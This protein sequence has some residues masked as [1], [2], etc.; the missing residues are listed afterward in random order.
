MEEGKKAGQHGVTP[1]KSSLA[2]LEDAIA[3][4]ESRTWQTLQEE[5]E[6]AVAFEEDAARLTAEEGALLKSYMRRDVGDLVSFMKDTGKGLREWLRFDLDVLEDGLKRSLL[7]IADHTLTD[8]QQLEHQLR[9]EEG[10]YVAGEVALPGML[11]C[12]QCGKMVC[13]VDVA[14]VQAC[15]RCDCAF[16]RRVTS[17]RT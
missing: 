5:I 12:V 3:D 9:H 15:H 2:R 4:L 11:Q 8:W 13:L 6:K 1:Y 10:S 16:F 17:R 14:E 7:A